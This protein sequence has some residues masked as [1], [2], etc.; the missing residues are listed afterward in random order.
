[1]NTENLL[2][3]ITLARIEYAKNNPD[4]PAKLYLDSVHAMKLEWHMKEHCIYKNESPVV[5]DGV[6]YNGMRVFPVMVA[7]EHI[8][9]S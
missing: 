4:N 9:V 2:R 7:E 5:K 3:A 6:Y 8:N 1:M